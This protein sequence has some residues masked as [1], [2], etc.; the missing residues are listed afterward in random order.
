MNL[1][2]AKQAKIEDLKIIGRRFDLDGDRIWLGKEPYDP[3]KYRTQK[4]E[5]L[6]N[7]QGLCVFQFPDGTYGLENFYGDVYK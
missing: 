1:E 6:R 4:Q 5:W 7:E 2:Q 3:L